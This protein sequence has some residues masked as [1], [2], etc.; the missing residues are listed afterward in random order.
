MSKYTSPLDNIRVASPCP[1]DWDQMYGNDRK[2]FC[3]QCKLNVY[4]LSA[5]TQDEAEELLRHSEGRLCVRYY[6]RADGT[7]LTQNCP[8]G[9]Q[10]V[11]RRVSNAV[12]A[13][14]SMII[15]IATGILGFNFIR[16]GQTSHQATV[17]TLVAPQS[18]ENPKPPFCDINRVRGEYELGERKPAIMGNVAV[19]VNVRSRR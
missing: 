19:P 3:G 10:A 2:R 16:E 11:K 5:M 1:A 12:T 4:N 14:F 8:V 7:V 17:G 9:W 15:G 6:R 18:V 13:V